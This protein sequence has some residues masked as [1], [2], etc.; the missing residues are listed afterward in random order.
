[1]HHKVLAK[2][3]NKMKSI[4]APKNS[5][6]TEGITESWPQFS[7]IWGRHAY[8][9]LPSAGENQIWRAKLFSLHWI[10]NLC[11][12]WLINGSVSIPDWH[13]ILC[14]WYRG[15]SYSMTFINWHRN[16]PKTDLLAI[17]SHR[18][19]GFWTISSGDFWDKSAV[20]FS[21][22]RSMAMTH[23]SAG[24]SWMSCCPGGSNRFEQ[25][26]LRAWRS[27]IEIHTISLHKDTHFVTWQTGTNAA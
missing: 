9:K 19:L 16:F 18:L 6:E 20:V 4:L 27:T 5:R 3:I 11:K 15:W 7:A 24:S 26:L 14:I 17:F 21:L 8:W 23:V 2:R 1:M 25:L 13:Q 22:L 10:S 12:I